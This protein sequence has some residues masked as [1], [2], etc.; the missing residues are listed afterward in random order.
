MAYFRLVYRSLFV[1]LILVVGV[2]LTPVVQGNTLRRKGLSAGINLAWHRWL[3]RALGIRISR[4]GAPDDDEPVL[5]VANHIS[6]FDISVL[7][8][9]VPVRFLSKHEVR[10]WPLI[11]WL[12]NKAGTLYIERGTKDASRRALATMSAALCDDQNV[13]LFPEGTTT[14]GNMKRFHG[15]LIQSAIDAGVKVQPVAIHYPPEQ[16]SDE[17]RMHPDILFTGD[18][19]LAESLSWMLKSSNLCAEL[20]FLDSFETGECNRDDIAVHCEALIRAKLDE[21]C[22]VGD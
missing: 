19:S 1:S 9:H 7:G 5:Y 6:W 2:V 20:H 15:R 16:R 17:C 22:R 4:H 10:H 21:R 8:A 11:G 12:A 3:A 13:C 14:D 18:T